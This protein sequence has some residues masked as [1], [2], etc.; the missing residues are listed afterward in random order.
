M[1]VVSA[2][3][4]N[5]DEIKKYDQIYSIEYFSIAIYDRGVHKFDLKSFKHSHDEYEFII[6]L[7]TIPLLY[8]AKANYIGE[9]GYVYPVNPQV[10]HGIEFDL[11]SNVISITISKRYVESVKNDLNFSGK[12]FYT[13]F[14]YKNTLLNFINKFKETFLSEDANKEYKL[15]QI[16]NSITTILVGNGLMSDTDNRRPEKQFNS[17]IKKSI[18]YI[19]ENYCD[20]TLTISKVADLSGYSLSYFSKVFQ[21]YMHEAPIEFLNKLRISKA[22][23]LI[24]DGGLKLGDI[25]KAVGYRNFSTFTEAFKHV[26]NMSPKDY[27]HKY[28]NI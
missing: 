26:M 19:N 23:Q 1:S 11:K 6:P 25:A 14:L 12:Y 21:A 7:E 27:K 10:E 5:S 4:V 16:A 9:V 13:R 3:G 24:M 20:N 15:H 2:H 18:I 17:S 22:K 8:Y 28:I